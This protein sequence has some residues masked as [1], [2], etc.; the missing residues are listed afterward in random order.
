[1]T[2][3]A[4]SLADLRDAMMAVSAEIAR[5]ESPEDNQQINWSDLPTFGGSDPRDAGA[6]D[7]V[8]SWDTTHM[9]VGA[10]VSEL[11]IVAR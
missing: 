8:W 11:R 7:P 4:V 2:N 10:C 3:I 1:M 6:S 9:L 5:S